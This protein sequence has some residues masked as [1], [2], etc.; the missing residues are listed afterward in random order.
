MMF[1]FDYISSLSKDYSADTHIHQMF[2]FN[3]CT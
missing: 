2:V 3:D 1:N